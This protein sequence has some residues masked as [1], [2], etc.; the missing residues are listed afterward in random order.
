M[1]DR[2][3]NAPIVEAIIDIQHRFMEPVSADRLEF[4]IDGYSQAE[5]LRKIGVEI[6]LN[7]GQLA[8]KGIDGGVFGYRYYS[9]GSGI[10]AQ[11]RANGVTVSKL[12]PYDSW[13]SFRP[14]AHEHWQKYCELVDTGADTV[15]RIAVRYINRLMVPMV[16]NEPIVIQ[17]YLKNAPETPDEANRPELEEFLCRMVMPLPE[18]EGKAII[19]SIMEPSERQYLPL[20]LDLDVFKHLGAPQEMTADQMWSIFEQMRDVKNELF[21]KIMT[22]KA[23]E[24][25]K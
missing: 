22:E 12:K 11:Y 14:I 7:E 6:Q 23:L 18:F 4:S 15:S 25:C 3:E 8:Q 5:P 19:H 21:S 24:L 9:P 1:L 10:A 17:D 20:V 13:E 2:L 16:S